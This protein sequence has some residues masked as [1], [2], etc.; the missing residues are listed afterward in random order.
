MIMLIYV[1]IAKDQVEVV[2]V[3]DDEVKAKEDDGVEK[4]QPAQKF[5]GKMPET[6][7]TTHTFCQPVQSK[8][9]WTFHKSH[10]MQKFRGQKMP[11]PRW[12]TL[13]KHHPKL[14]AR[15]LQC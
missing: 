1:G 7:N 2:T 5:T 10:C 11:E 13:I 14:T 8:C 15:T 3:E 6:K 4:S 12:S 9:T